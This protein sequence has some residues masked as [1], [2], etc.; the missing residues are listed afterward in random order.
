MRIPEYHSYEKI[1]EYFKIEYIYPQ[2]T[3]VYKAFIFI[4]MV[5]MYLQHCW[6]VYFCVWAVLSNYLYALCR[7]I[8]FYISGRSNLAIVLIKS[9]RRGK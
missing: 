4:T 2:S 5:Y 9:N 3:A 8:F 7:K 6:A 1:L